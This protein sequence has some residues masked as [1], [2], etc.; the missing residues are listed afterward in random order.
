MKIKVDG[1]WKE[2]KFSTSSGYNT[3]V[4]G[5]TQNEFLGIFQRACETYIFTNVNTVQDEN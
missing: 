5:D 1:Q 3:I 4:E 2:I